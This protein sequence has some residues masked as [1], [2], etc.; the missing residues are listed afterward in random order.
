MQ[1]TIKNLQNNY[2]RKNEYRFRGI[3]RSEKFSKIIIMR[4]VR[5]FLK[6]I[7]VV[8]FIFREVVC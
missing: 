7:S 6:E 8:E 5:Y 3:S 2:I 1:D 4:N